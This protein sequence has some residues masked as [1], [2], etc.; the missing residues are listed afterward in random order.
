MMMEA[1]EDNPRLEEPSAP[2][3]WRV[4][5]IAAGGGSDA[6]SAELGNTARRPLQPK[7]L[8][9]LRT[10]SHLSYSVDDLIS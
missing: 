10:L 5:P 6:S 9:E 3:S 8:I 2:A 4:P 7:R 1:A